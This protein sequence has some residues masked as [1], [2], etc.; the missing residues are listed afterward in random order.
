MRAAP[1]MRGRGLRFSGDDD[2]GGVS[3]VA[4]DWRLDEELVGAA[5]A[6]AGGV[7]WRPLEIFATGGAESCGSSAGSTAERPESV[8]RLRRLSSERMSEACW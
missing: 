2:G 8:S 3:G 1:A 5:G 4:T 6:A 7:L